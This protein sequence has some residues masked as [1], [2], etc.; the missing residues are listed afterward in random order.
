MAR[1]PMRTIALANSKGGVGKTTLI[2]AL[3]VSAAR[4]GRVA[5]IDLDPRA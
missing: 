4:E 1:R 3:A 5:L 2:T